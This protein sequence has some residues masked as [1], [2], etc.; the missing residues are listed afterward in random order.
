MTGNIRGI[1]KGD[2]APDVVKNNVFAMAAGLAIR[3]GVEMRDL[4]RLSE[5]EPRK[6]DFW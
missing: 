1:S 3:R 4:V 5:I 6:K 2:I